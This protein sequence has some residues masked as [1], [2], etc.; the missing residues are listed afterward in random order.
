M[1]FLSFMA[2]LGAVLRDVFVRPTAAAGRATLAAMGS[3]APRRAEPED[4]SAWRMSHDEW[5]AG[6]DRQMGRTR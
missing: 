3:Q 6:Y 1:I 4:P 5:Q 2:F